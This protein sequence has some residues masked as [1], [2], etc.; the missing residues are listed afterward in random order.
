MG[1]LVNYE[2]TPGA[3]GAPPAAWPADSRIQRTPGRA[4]LVMLAHP[5]CPCTRAS[6]EE[7]AQFV[8]RCQGLL[9]THVLFLKPAGF[10]EDWTQTDLYQSAA[11]IPGVRV[12]CDEGGVE[13]RRFGATT[14]GQTFLYRSD[15]RLLFRGGITSSRGHVGDNAGRNA[16][17]SILTEGTADRTETLAF[18][19][20]LFGPQPENAGAKR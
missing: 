12:A 3:S 10:S 11:R 15:G 20:G 17:V 8:T 16:I 7:L 1:I 19:C 13:A 5:H 2:N 9:T 18:G 6:V 4:T 14:S